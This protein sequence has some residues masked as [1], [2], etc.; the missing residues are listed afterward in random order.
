M[1]RQ[2][3]G[4][5]QDAADANYFWAKRAVKQEMPWLSHTRRGRDTRT[6]I[7]Q[8]IG[9]DGFPDFRTR[10]AAGAMRIDGDIAKADGE[11]R[12]VAKPRRFAEC[13]LRSREDCDD[14]VFRERR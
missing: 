11:Q 2:V 8:M 4:V 12:F 7:P 14:V 9:A 1:L 13:L 3:H 6:A 5:V 10:G